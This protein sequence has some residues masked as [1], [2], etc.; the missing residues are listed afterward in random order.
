MVSFLDKEHRKQPIAR[1][2]PRCARVEVAISG[3]EKGSQLFELVV[4]LDNDRVSHK[5]HVEG[6][7][8][9]IDA[10]YMKAVEAACLADKMVQ[11]EIKTLDLP[12]GATVVV[13]PWAYA[14]DGMN[15]MATR[16]TMVSPS[17]RARRF[18]EL[19]PLIL[20]SAGFIFDYKTIR[21]QI[22]MH[23]PSTFVRKPQKTL[24]LLRSIA[25]QRSRTKE[26]IMSKSHLTVVG[27]TLRPRVNTIRA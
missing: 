27:F 5:Q 11:A 1:P 24:R 26:S 16:V 12:E 4:D 19:S 22:T 7:H 21:K 3:A 25:C 18:I 10:E 6:K 23:I 9:Y 14:T 15:D 8:S 13:E 20:S 2:P 17:T